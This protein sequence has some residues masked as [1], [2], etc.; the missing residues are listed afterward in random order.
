MIRYVDMTADLEWSVAEDGCDAD[1]VK[2]LDA[3][4]LRS[5]VALAVAHKNISSS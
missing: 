5:V 1:E 2:Y 4:T 3:L